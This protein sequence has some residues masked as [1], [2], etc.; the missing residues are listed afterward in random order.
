VLYYAGSKKRVTVEITAELVAVTKRAAEAAFRTSEG[1]KL[2]PPLIDSPKCPRC[3]LVGIC[4]PDEVNALSHEKD[5]GVDVRRLFPARDDALPLYVTEQGAVVGRSGETIEVRY[6]GKILGRARMIDTSQLCVFGGVNVTPS[7]VH[8]FCESGRPICHYS[9]GGW[10]Y[11]ITHGMPHKNVG[12]RILQYRRA[13]SKSESLT[14]A[15]S[16]VEGKIRNCRTM[17]KRNHPD[18]PKNLLSELQRLA[19]LAGLSNDADSL[20]G[21]EGAAANVYFSIFGSMIKGDEGEGF[22]FLSRNRR[23]PTDP[24]N[25]LISF[26]YSLL[27]KEIT[28]VLMAVGFDPYLGFYHT[29]RYGRPALALDLMEEFRPIIADSVA[30]TMLNRKEVTRA[31]FVIVGQACALTQGGRRKVIEGYHRRL[32]ALVTHPVFGYSISYGRILEVQARL[33]GRWLQGEIPRYP[34]FHT[35]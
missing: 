24:V 14:A 13:E 30:L 28:V 32:D 29:P 25:A 34:F 9:F 6:R 8:S 23:P 12:L 7:V 10:F 31:D 19:R 27:V 18:P 17:A 26:L 5:E 1:S 16:F 15:R 11:G 21:I 4:L 20:R 33:L 22:S 2:P 35:R 3:S